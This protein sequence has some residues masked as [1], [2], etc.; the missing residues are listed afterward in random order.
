MRGRS[1]SGCSI[2]I[3]PWRFAGG[4]QIVINAAAARLIAKHKFCQLGIDKD[5]G[6]LLLKFGPDGDIKGSHKLRYP[7]SEGKGIAMNARAFLQWAGLDVSKSSTHPVRDY[8]QAKRLLT[9]KLTA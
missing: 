7:K 8:D 4:G 9:V 1:T 3:L 6:L 2:E 5:E